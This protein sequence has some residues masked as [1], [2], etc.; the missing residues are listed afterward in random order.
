MRWQTVKAATLLYWYPVVSYSDPS[1]IAH[2]VVG[3]TGCSS[4]SEPKSRPSYRVRYKSDSPHI[5]QLSSAF[6]FWAAPL[7]FAVFATF[8]SVAYLDVTG[9]IDIPNAR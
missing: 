6:H 8:V 9:F 3:N 2:E 7:F 5:A 4:R 1:G